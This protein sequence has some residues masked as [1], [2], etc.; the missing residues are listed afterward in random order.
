MIKTKINYNWLLKKKTLKI[1][2]GRKK[3]VFKDKNK[4]LSNS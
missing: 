2:R 3:N 4:Q 1:W